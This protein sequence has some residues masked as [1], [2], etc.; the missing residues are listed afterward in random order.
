MEH[1]SRIYNAN[2]VAIVGPGN[3]LAGQAYDIPSNKTVAAF[4]GELDLGMAYRFAPRWSAT[5]GYRAIAIS[6]LAYATEQIPGNLA[7][8]PGV[9]SIDNNANMILHGAYAG[10]TFGW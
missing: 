7:D 9:E 6:G 10:I 4:I 2:G 8:L 1:H 3:P 5:L